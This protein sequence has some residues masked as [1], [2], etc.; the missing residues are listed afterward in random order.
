[1]PRSRASRLGRATEFCLDAFGAQLVFCPMLAQA[2]PVNI[3]RN[4][5][6][7]QDD[8]VASSWFV[9]VLCS[10]RARHQAKHSRFVRA[11]ADMNVS[12]AIRQHPS[13]RRRAGCGCE[14]QT[15]GC[16]R[17][18]MGRSSHAEHASILGNACLRIS[19]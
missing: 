14:G 11:V 10:G 3:A 1:M 19:A 12:S 9:W 17:V 15:G 8:F 2:D 6:C 18:G 13:V 16:V 7:T 4:T 5:Q